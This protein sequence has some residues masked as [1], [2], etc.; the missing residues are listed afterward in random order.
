MLQAGAAGITMCLGCQY[1]VQHDK[2]RTFVLSTRL[3]SCKFSQHSS[4]APV[5]EMARCA[6]FHA[7]PPVGCYRARLCLPRVQPPLSLCICDS[8]RQ[9][10][11]PAGCRSNLQPTIEAATSCCCHMLVCSSCNINVTTFCSSCR[12]NRDVELQGQRMAKRSDSSFRSAQRC[13]EVNVI[14]DITFPARLT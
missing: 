9:R 4:A 13:L 11:L 8:T 7:C 12:A 6:A 3:L 2:Q 5:L 1:V 10:A 14:S